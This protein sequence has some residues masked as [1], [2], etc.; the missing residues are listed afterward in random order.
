MRGLAALL[1]VLALA[2]AAA[3][4]DDASEARFFDQL[5]RRAFDHGDYRTAL[6]HFLLAHGAAGSSAIAFNVAVCA[7][8]VGEPRMAFTYFQRFLDDADAPADRRARAL[9]ALARLRPRLRVVTVRSEPSGA[10]V[11]LDTEE[12]G[13]FGRTPLEIALE[14]GEAH[15]L[16]L[17]AEGHHDATRTLD[18]EVASGADIVVPLLPRAGEVF[19][20]VAPEDA[21][22]EVLR[23]E[24]VLARQTGDGSLALPVG[25]YR[26][27]VTAPGHAPGDRLVAVSEATDQSLAVELTPIRGRTALLLLTAGDEPAL[28]TLD[29]RPV[30]RTPLRLPGVVP[31]IH[32]LE[33]RADD[34]RL[35]RGRV[36][37]DAGDARL[38][39]VRL[40]QNG[41]RQERPRAP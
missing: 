20:D 22:V 34:G 1:V 31:G 13:V 25:R 38:L 23:G 6:E 35:W 9:E 3:R 21:E 39:R 27:R 2:P 28:V 24:E 18:A 4:A 17:R 29:G 41:R 8:L 32:R 10:L 11:F 30:G 16:L 36:R 37:L 7:D 19:L 33:V 14:P 5:G 26:V 12:R 40:D 15:A